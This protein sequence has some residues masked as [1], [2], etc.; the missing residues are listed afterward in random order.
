MSAILVLL[1]NPPIHHGTRRKSVAWS[2]AVGQCPL[3]LSSVVTGG[4]HFATD[5][6][7]NCPENSEASFFC[8]KELSKAREA[9]RLAEPNGLANT[10][11]CLARHVEVSLLTKEIEQTK[12]KQEI[13]LVRVGSAASLRD[14]PLYTTETVDDCWK[15]TRS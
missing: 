1:N 7:W 9:K 11:V 6:H 15:K 5:S 12:P 2:A 4:H 8:P 14:T 3:N 10:E 13:R